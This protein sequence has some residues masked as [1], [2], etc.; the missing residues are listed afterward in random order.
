MAQVVRVFA[1]G[2]VLIAILCPARTQ[3]ASCTNGPCCKQSDI[4]GPIIQPKHNEDEEGKGDIN[5]GGLTVLSGVLAVG[6]GLRSGSNKITATLDKNFEA[7]S[8]AI[9]QM[10]TSLGAAKQKSAMREMFGPNSGA[11]MAKQDF[12]EQVESGFAARDEFASRVRADLHDYLRKFDTKKG[13]HKRLENAPDTGALYRTSGTM[14]PEQLYRTKEWAKT[15]LDP[16]P[17]RNLPQKDMKLSRD[18]SA[19]RKA[20]ETKLLIPEAVLSDLI[21]A[22]APTVDMKGW[23][24]RMHKKMGGKGSPQETV[25]GKLSAN[26]LMAT[27]A[28]ARFANQDWLSGKDG[29]HGK[30]RTGTLRELLQMRVDKLMMELRQ[31]RWMDRMAAV[32]AGRVLSGNARF[33]DMLRKLKSE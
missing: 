32:M 27:L 16:T 24:A 3:A 14:T 12:G 25:D 18:Y 20:K 9:R 6:Q 19:I 33:N 11:Y 31:M 21:A 8:A 22:R 2:L 5:L 7:Q 13:Y 26:S 10:L 30:T 29:I 15:T 17:A 1:V 28:D 23:P 4:K